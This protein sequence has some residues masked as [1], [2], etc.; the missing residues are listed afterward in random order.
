MSVKLDLKN[1][2]I[3]GDFS[4]FQRNTSFAAIAD[5]TYT[6]D[7]WMYRKTGTMVHTVS[8]SSDVPSSAFGIYSLLS[9]CT[10]AQVSIGAND[11]TLIS[12]RIEGNILR[13]FKNKKVVLSFWV[14]STK[15]GTFCISIRNATDTRSLIKE[16]TISASNTWEKKIVRFQHDS[17]GT[18]DYANGIGLKLGFVLACGSNL[19]ASANSWQSGNFIATSNQVNACDNIVNN[20]WLTDACLQEDN[21]G[22]TREPE[23][24]LAGRDIFEELQ[25][26]QRYY[27]V[28][29]VAS[30]GTAASTFSRWWSSY[31]TE[32]RIV[33]VVTY[34]IITGQNASA[35]S[36][37][38]V[39]TV[40]GAAGRSNGANIN[41]WTAWTF[42]ADA[43]L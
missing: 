34:T 12:Q 6:A 28:G 39:N 35:P 16:Y 33:P 13:S 11:Y 42:R 37:V 20:F 19:R 38:D 32:K 8:R 26:C 36:V 15:T 5:S 30:S 41:D 31:K 23:F 25:L 22:Q 29:M 43:E 40:F 17:F 1:A 10:T 4:Y 2:L 7:R 21:E 18:W 27:E 3:N 9:D 14:K 24:R